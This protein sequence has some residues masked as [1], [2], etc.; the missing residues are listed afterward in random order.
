MA[1]CDYVGLL[2]YRVNLVPAGPDPDLRRAV[3]IGAR[4][5]RWSV[6]S[7]SF[8]RIAPIT[9]LTRWFKPSWSISRAMNAI[10]CAS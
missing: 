2:G 9:S 10:S 3:A 7:T 4:S 5:C 1:V 8:A 6:A